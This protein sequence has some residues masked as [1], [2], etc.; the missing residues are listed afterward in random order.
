[1]IS[2]VIGGARSGKSSFAE[3]IYEDKKDVVYMAT[4]R[5]EDE[6]MRERVRLHRASRPDY[7]RT[8]EGSYKLTEALGSERFYLLDCITVLTSNIMFDLSR[9]L[10]YID[11]SL[12]KEIEDRVMEEVEGLIKQVRESSYS[13]V[14]VSNEVGYSLVPENHI[15][16]VFRDIQGRVNQKIAYL[17]DEVYLLVAGIPVKIK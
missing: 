10:E 4:S 13:L 14:L 3:K 6:E 12:Q 16:R 9:G 11:S 8:F 15:S 17:A 5:L 2:F 7:W 1:M